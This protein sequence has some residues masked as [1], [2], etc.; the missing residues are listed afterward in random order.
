MME[1]LEYDREWER[2][3]D[4]EFKLWW[5]AKPEGSKVSNKM[6]VLK[7]PALKSMR[8]RVE[9]GWLAKSGATGNQRIAESK[10]FKNWWASK[11]KE[12]KITNRTFVLRRAYGPTRSWV[13]EGWLAYASSNSSKKLRLC[14][15]CQQMAKK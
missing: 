4:G 10:R 8:S 11:L 9:E 5:K 2:A 7:N 1:R 13:N 6:A 3:E 14:K 15:V 12:S